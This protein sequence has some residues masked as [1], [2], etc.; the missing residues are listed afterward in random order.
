MGSMASPVKKIDHMDF[1]KIPA[2]R[3]IRGRIVQSGG[4]IVVQ[5]E[6]GALYTNVT[7]LNRHAHCTGRWQW[8][9]EIHACLDALG[10][11]T[12]EERESHQEWLDYL[13]QQSEIVDQI[14]EAK[15][16]KSIGAVLVKVDHNKLMALWESLDYAH[17]KK[18]ERY[19]YMPEGAQIKPV[20]Q[21]LP[22]G[23]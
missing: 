14:G 4:T 1:K 16:A 10:L 23:S 20:P 13:K 19:G 22:T 8:S 9:D 12:P 3:A 5:G 2:N 15:R 21:L 18:A 6:K 7:P 11:L 17:Q